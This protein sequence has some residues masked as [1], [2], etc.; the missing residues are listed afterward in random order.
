VALERLIPLIE[1]DFAASAAA[2][3]ES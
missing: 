1:R 2:G 3:T